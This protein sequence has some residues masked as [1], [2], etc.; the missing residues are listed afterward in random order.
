MYYIS[1]HKTQAYHSGNAEG[2]IGHPVAQ[3]HT[4]QQEVRHSPET[5]TLL[6]HRD[7]N[8]FYMG[9]VSHR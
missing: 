9:R 2:S 6:R 3:A 4:P 1:I 5:G 8:I 7:K